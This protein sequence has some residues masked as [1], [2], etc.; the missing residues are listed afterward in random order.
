[1][2]KYFVLDDSDSEEEYSI[3]DNDVQ[4]SSKSESAS[5]N[6]RVERGQPC[7]HLLKVRPKTHSITAGFSA[8]SKV[9]VRRFSFMK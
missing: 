3:S 8:I 9:N 7:H 6:K 5:L 1:M 2:T 4:S